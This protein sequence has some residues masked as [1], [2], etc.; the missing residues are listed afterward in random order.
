MV[1]F[2]R[3]PRPSLGVF[4]PRTFALALAVCVA[5]FLA[6]ALAPVPLFGLGGLLGVF[7]AG[8]LL[9]L[10]R[11]AYVETALAGGASAGVGTVLS[12]FLASLAVGAVPVAAVGAGAG[13]LAALGGHY[14]GRDLRAGV[15]REL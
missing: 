5:G 8:F 3:V 12:S 9:G 11:R 15:D 13:L 4:S 10:R 2:P 6:G 14:S 7:A 1:T